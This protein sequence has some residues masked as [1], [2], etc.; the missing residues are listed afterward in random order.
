MPSASSSWTTKKAPPLPRSDEAP[1][2]RWPACGGGR[3]GRRLADGP[4]APQAGPG[5][6]RS[7]PG[8]AA[9]TRPGA[10]PLVVMP[11]DLTLSRFRIERGHLAPRLRDALAQVGRLEHLEVGAEAEQLAIG[12]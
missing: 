7:P 8:P 2:P 10:R 4:D 6:R 11:G 5:P 12:V 9:R 3:P 1:L